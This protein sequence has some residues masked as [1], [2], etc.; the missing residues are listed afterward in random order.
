L[1]EGE[2]ALEK[3]A[4]RDH[5]KKLRLNLSR[6]EVLSA[7]SKIQKRLFVLPDF[8]DSRTVCFYVAKGNEVQTEHMIRKSLRAGRRVLVPLVNV[9][10][11]LLLVSELTDYDQNLEAGTFGVLEPKPMFRRIVPSTEANL[12][13][14]PGVAFDKHG[15]RLGYGKGYYDRFL[16]ILSQ[17]QSHA[18]FIGLAYDFQ[19]LEMIPHTRNDISLHKIVT[20]KRIV[21]PKNKRVEPCAS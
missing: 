11:G 8:V 15:H 20:E 6:D 18:K 19:I 14:V 2:I 12:V 21:E 1:V 7:S 9:Q 4:T 17:S 16:N 13:L 3:E 5:F 10:S